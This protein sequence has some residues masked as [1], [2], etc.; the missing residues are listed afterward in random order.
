M[1]IRTAAQDKVL[2]ILLEM[3]RPTKRTKEDLDLLNIAETLHQFSS[4]AV[5][6]EH[7]WL[8]VI[9]TNMIHHFRERGHDFNLP[10]STPTPRANKWKQT[11]LKV[12][13]PLLE[14]AK[15]MWTLKETSRREALL[16]ASLPDSRRQ[17]E[18]HQRR[19]GDIRSWLKRL[20]HKVGTLR[21]PP[22]QALNI[23]TTPTADLLR[24]TASNLHPTYTRLTPARVIP[25][26]PKPTTRWKNTLIQDHFKLNRTNSANMIK[27][28][29]RP[30]GR[31][32]NLRT[33]ETGR[34]D[35]SIDLDWLPPK[36]SEDAESEQELP[37]RQLA[38]IATDERVDR[39]D[40]DNIYL[41]NYLNN[42]NI[43][44]LAAC[45]T[46]NNTLISCDSTGDS[47]SSFNNL[48]EDDATKRRG[49]G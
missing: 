7:L 31:M 9:Y 45:C 6:G 13:T 40:R 5:N 44:N 18:L 8:G 32:P 33:L 27:K 30:D 25:P 22:V 11:V 12:I 46:I 1:K 19:R 49:V 15:D 41:A 21:R 47:R 29:L 23:D 39:V 38:T 36:S 4:S 14:A 16:G 34:W 37:E 28:N 35:N 42:T 26:P 2:D 24:E 20:E 17:H 43:P 48:A 10:D 3:R